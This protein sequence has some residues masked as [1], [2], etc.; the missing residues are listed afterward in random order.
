MSKFRIY[1]D[2]Q[3][4]A[5]A[6]ADY[7]VKHSTEAIAARGRFLIALAGGNTPRATYA[8]LAT[9]PYASRVDW[10]NVHV[11]WSD[12]RSVSPDHPESN[13]RMAQETLLDH[14]P[15]L[16][17]HIYRI[18]GEVVPDWAASSYEMEM[19]RILGSDGRFDLIL[20][21]MGADGHTAS[22][23]PHTT[24]LEEKEY[25]FN[26]IHLGPPRGWRVTMTLPCI[27]AA[28]HVLFLV[29][30]EEKAE[31]LARV[32]AGEPLP[33]ALVQPEDGELVWM[34]D[35]AATGKQNE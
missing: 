17:E 18:R 34:V 21:G 7:I 35:Q 10:S 27:N 32:Q 29:A 8:A 20:L 5:Q 26:A 19:L 25:P 11:F 1:P 9:E 2:P 3:G 22:L 15:I 14:V 30:G 12:E 13:Y 24:V 6:A 23:F 28:R 16:E 4:L 33:A 31:A